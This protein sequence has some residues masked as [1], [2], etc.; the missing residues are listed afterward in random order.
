MKMP[1]ILNGE[2]IAP[3]DSGPPDGR[4]WANI[5]DLALDR[6][7]PSHHLIPTRW[8]EL[9]GAKLDAMRWT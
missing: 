9:G 1:A 4:A 8:M 5:A 2:N 6:H 7:K 3:I